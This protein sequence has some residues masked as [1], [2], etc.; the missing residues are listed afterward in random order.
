MSRKSIKDDILG[1]YLVSAGTEI[2]ISPDLIQRS[3]QLWD[4]PDRFDPDRPNSDS[5]ALAFRPFGAGPRKCIGDVFARVEIQIHLMMFAKE[6]LL[7]CCET[8][9]PEVYDRI[10]F[11]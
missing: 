2:Y 3:P 7:R 4:L 10:E 1:E 5:R 9:V 6:F 11:A 8:G